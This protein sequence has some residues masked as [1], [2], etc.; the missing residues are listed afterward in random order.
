MGC[1]DWPKCYGM[2]APP[3]CDCSL[4]SNYQEIFLK[5]RIA[6]LQRLSHTLHALGFHEKADAILKDP[7]VYKDE[8]FNAIKAWTEYI[9]RLF[10]VLTGFAGLAFL[11]SAFGYRRNLSVFIPAA[12]G[13]L[14]IVFN[15]WLGSLVVVTN[16]LSGTV[17]LHYLLAFL[18]VY[19]I[20]LAVQRSRQTEASAKI[21]GRGM[22]FLFLIA[23]MVQ[24]LAG[25]YVRENAD[26][27]M[28]RGFTFSL[29]M[30][31]NLLGVSFWIHRGLAVLLLLGNIWWY[32]QLRKQNT[33]RNILRLQVLAVVLL[34]SQFISGTLNLYLNFPVVPQVWHITAGGLIFAIQAYI[35]TLRLQA[36]NSV[37]PAH[38]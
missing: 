34:L 12:A 2:I 21:P 16:L 24:L 37:V 9:N 4:P 7:A 17:S 14:A 35:C 38:Q 8:P 3:T 5:K 27:L 26:E 11:I 15:G 33:P 1:P 25:T 10:G 30:D 6:K 13:V 18:S 28:N 20:I 36:E 31:Y 32:Y 19:W 23:L 29:G 22:W